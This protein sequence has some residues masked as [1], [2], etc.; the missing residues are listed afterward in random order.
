MSNSLQKAMRRAL[1]ERDVTVAQLGR[2]AGCSRPSIYLWLG[3]HRSMSV[4]RVEHLFSILGLAMTV[5]PSPVPQVPDVP[6]APPIAAL[7]VRP[8]AQRLQLT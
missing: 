5:E 2:M 8:R 7:T 1:R 3:G 6:N 4:D